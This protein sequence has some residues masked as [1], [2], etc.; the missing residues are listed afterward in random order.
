MKTA[1]SW[2]ILMLLVFPI[3]SVAETIY[4]WTDENGVTRFSNGS[5]PENVKAY[6]V[7]ETSPADSSGFESDNKRRSSYDQMIDRAVE[8]GK[9]S[10]EKRKKEEADKAA[11]KVRALET[12]KEANRQAER[13]QLEAQIE[14]IKKRA[15]SPTFPNGMKQAQIDALKKKIEAVEKGSTPST[16]TETPSRSDEKFSNS[17]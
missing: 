4:S 15:V 5:P 14:A 13:K 7:I 11:E 1:I 12:Q 2:I 8:D 16:K 17:Y 9:A 3:T 10:E 6:K